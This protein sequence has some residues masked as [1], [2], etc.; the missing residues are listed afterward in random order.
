MPSEHF[1]WEE[2]VKSSNDCSIG[3]SSIGCFLVYDRI[4]SA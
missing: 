1:Y 4:V 3:V 2:A